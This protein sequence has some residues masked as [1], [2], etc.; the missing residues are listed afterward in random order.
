MCCVCACERVPT[1]VACETEM[2]EDILNEKLQ[3]KLKFIN[4]YL[5]L[6][7]FLNQLRIVNI[8]CKKLRLSGDLRRHHYHL[9][10]LAN[11]L[12]ERSLHL[13]ASRRDDLMINSPYLTR[14]AV[15]T[16]LI[17]LTVQVSPPKELYC[18]KVG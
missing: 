10:S 12:A 2:P 17:P 14:E 8:S 13:R 9:F 15:S 1:H 11:D 16:R 4:S 5:N 6:D 3:R 18:P 7:I